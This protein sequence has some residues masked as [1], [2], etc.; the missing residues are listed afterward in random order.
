M[1]KPTK[2][3]D[4]WKL[5]V[6]VALCWLMLNTY[7]LSL[8]FSKVTKLSALITS[9]NVTYPVSIFPEYTEIPTKSTMVKTGYFLLAMSPLL[10]GIVFVIL[11]VGM[12]VWYRK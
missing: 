11:I 4:L 5:L 8:L 7:Y 3:L 10:I 12:L 6:I 2:K 9:P 1:T